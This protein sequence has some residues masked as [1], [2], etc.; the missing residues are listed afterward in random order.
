M[1]W[2]KCEW[3]RVQQT[4]ERTA[5]TKCCTK[6]NIIFQI[7]K[8]S[9]EWRWYWKKKERVNDTKERGCVCL[10]RKLRVMTSKGF[11]IDIRVS[12]RQRKEW[13]SFFLLL[14]SL[15]IVGS[16]CTHLSNARLHSMLTNCA[17][18]CRFVMRERWCD[19][20]LWSE[21]GWSQNSNYVKCEFVEMEMNPKKWFSLFTSLKCFP[22]SFEFFEFNFHIIAILCQLLPLPT[23]MHSMKLKWKMVAHERQR[24]GSFRVQVKIYMQRRDVSVNKFVTIN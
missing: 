3:H 11:S 13:I 14:L 1:D 8:N 9:G 19:A 21:L 15:R 17:C 7:E 12:F 5:S 18:R 20:R 24:S 22:N 6:W 16:S 4:N 2:L 23:R 10:R